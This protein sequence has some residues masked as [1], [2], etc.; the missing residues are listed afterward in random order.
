MKKYFIN[1]LL[2]FVP[3]II[4]SQTTFKGM[5]MEKNNLKNNLGVEGA[6]LFWLNT[7]VS[8]I[9]NSKG[10]FTIPYN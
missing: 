1:S 9:T 10:W 6:T 4:F 2:L 8:A 3:L 5:I 7:N